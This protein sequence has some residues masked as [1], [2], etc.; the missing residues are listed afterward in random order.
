MLRD[1]V[2][3]AA[4]GLPPL[5]LIVWLG[6]DWFPLFTLMIAAV[7]AWASFEF[8]GMVKR[9]GYHPLTIPGTLL[10][11]LLVGSFS[12]GKGNPFSLLI[13]SFDVRGGAPS[14]ILALGVG[15]SLVIFL[16][17]R[18][19]VTALTDWALTLAGILYI[20]FLYG[21]FILLR[22]HQPYGR[23]WL[24][25]V[26][27]STF[28]SD[29]VAYFVGRRFGAHRLAPVIS[30]KKSWEGT[31]AGWLGAVGAAL[32]MFWLFQLP[33]FP[34]QAIVL[35]GIVGI[36]GQLG[37]LGESLLKRSAGVKDASSAIPGHGGLLD[38]M[39]SLAFATVAAY[40]YIALVMIT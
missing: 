16:F 2:L 27:A 32:L 14:S 23:E 28:A 24:L 40:H 35:G 37:D 9:A 6:D 1:R 29:T 8:Y 30:P 22:D 3:S 34:F 4:V 11:V 25:L 39:D 20:G 5:L 15:L 7:A 38:R 21:Y 36:V 13:G 12:L 31:V 19:T 26:L 18:S 33:G 17:H 10:S